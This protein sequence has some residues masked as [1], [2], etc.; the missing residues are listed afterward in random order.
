MNVARRRPTT[1]DGRAPGRRPALHRRAIRLRIDA[2]PGARARNDAR[3]AATLRMRCAKARRTHAVGAR[4]RD[5]RAAGAE[6]EIGRWAAGFIDLELARAQRRRSLAIACVLEHDRRGVMPHAR[7]ACAIDRIPR[8]KCRDQRRAR[9]AQRAPRQVSSPKSSCWQLDREHVAR[10]Y[11]LQ[12]S[13]IR[14]PRAVRN[15]SVSLQEPVTPSC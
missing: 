2:E 10:V 5:R 14:A 1:G 4:R 12:R 9:A 15:M 7:R 11:R 3:P 13:G 6:D 8:S